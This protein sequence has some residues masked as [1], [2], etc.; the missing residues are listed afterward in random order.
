M[1]PHPIDTAMQAIRLTGNLET[2]ARKTFIRVPHYVQPSFDK[3]LAACA[4]PIKAAG[5]P[6]PQSDQRP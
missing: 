4:K 1:T 6:L 2:I 3:A 5:R